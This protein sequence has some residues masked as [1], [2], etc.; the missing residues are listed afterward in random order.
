[1]TAI[2]NMDNINVIVSVVFLFT[3]NRDMAIAR[4]S[5]SFKIILRSLWYNHLSSNFSMIFI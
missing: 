3:V 2:W 4:E 5:F 1:M